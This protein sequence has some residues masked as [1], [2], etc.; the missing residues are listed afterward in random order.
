[1]DDRFGVGRR[2]EDGAV[3]HE[4]GAQR[5]RIGEIAVVCQR[6]RAA[7][8]IGIHGLDVA[9]EGTTGRRIAHVTQ[10]LRAFQLVRMLTVLAERVAHETGVA[11]GNELHAVIGD[12]ADGFL[13]AML[14][15]MKTKDG[16]RAR[17]G[18][19]EDAEHAAFF[20][21]GVVVEGCLGQL[22]G[23]LLAATV[24]RRFDEVV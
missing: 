12:D 23:H 10:R 13:S 5:V 3:A 11:L 2:L 4:F 24:T 7:G 22:L 20:M 8:E 16:Q 17:V 18:M 15:R 21:Q 19:S 1:M 6:N 14:K 9:R